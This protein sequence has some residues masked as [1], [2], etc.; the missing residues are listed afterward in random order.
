MKVMDCVA[1]IVLTVPNASIAASRPS[2]GTW[3]PISWIGIWLLQKLTGSWLPVTFRMLSLLNPVLPGS[4]EWWSLEPPPHGPQLLSL[5]SFHPLPPLSDPM[6]GAVFV[7][8]VLVSVGV[9]V[10]PSV[11]LVVVWSPVLP[12]PSRAVMFCSGTC[13]PIPWIGI[14]LLQA[15]IG[16]WLPLR[17]RMLSP[18]KPVLLPGPWT[19]AAEAIGAQ[20]PASAAVAMARAKARF[21]PDI[22]Y[23][24]P[25]NMVDSSRG[26]A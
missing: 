21:F 4:L 2:A 3:A 14:W 26:S 24:P 15:L 5:P 25:F 20:K 23:V 1:L 12:R 9:L 8:L 22:L 16:S 13:A 18:W 11:L 7:V 17:L 19:V 6:V 10:Q